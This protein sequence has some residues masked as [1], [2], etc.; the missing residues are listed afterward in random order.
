MALCCSPD[1]ALWWL[2]EMAEAALDGDP[3]ACRCLPAAVE[4]WLLS[5]S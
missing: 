5:L 3:D 1:L 4:H 2:L